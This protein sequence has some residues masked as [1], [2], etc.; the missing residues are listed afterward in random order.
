MEQMSLFEDDFEF[1][2]NQ[3]KYD[4]NGVEKRCHKGQLWQ[5]GKHRLLCGDATNLDDIKKLTGG[6]LSI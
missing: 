5:L 2:Q 4:E 3:D 1:N 6:I